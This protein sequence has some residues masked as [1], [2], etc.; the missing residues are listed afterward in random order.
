M[1]T[2]PAN[3]L[4]YGGREVARKSAQTSSAVMKIA[5][6]KIVVEE[7]FNSRKDFEG[8]EELSDSIAA[9]GQTQ[10]GIVEV[11]AD[12]NF[13]L[14]DGERRYRALLRLQ[15]QHPEL[16]VKFLA[17]IKKLTEIE[18]ILL[19]FTSQD[20]SPHKPHEVAECLTRLKNLGLNQRE[21]A[22][23]TG[24]TE[25]WVSMLIG[26]SKENAEIKKEVEA[27]NLSVSAAMKLKREIPDEAERVAAVKA[28]V[29]EHNEK[30][31]IYIPEFHDN[32]NDGESMLPDPSIA[33]E[34]ERLPDNRQKITASKIAKS[35]NK[36]VAEIMQAI[37]LEKFE[38][39]HVPPFHHQ[40]I[41][42]IQTVLER[43]F[44]S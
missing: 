14:R 22:Q 10:A 25:A 44:K 12:G 13:V 4:I 17:T 15:K 37:H 6:D 38:N 35:N 31:K 41:I 30:H 21:I 34:T 16:E 27:G 32:D 1:K 43:F 26:Y 8:I 11:L 19:L 18:R 5:L 20:S 7:G 23:K 24:K 28:A 2:I 33:H 29:N 3:Q 36:K 39:A 42:I 9:N 40:Q